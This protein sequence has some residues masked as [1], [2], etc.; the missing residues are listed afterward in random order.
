MWLFKNILGTLLE[1]Q[2]SSSFYYKINLLWSLFILRLSPEIQ[3]T[4]IDFGVHFQIVKYSTLHTHTQEYYNLQNLVELPTWSLDTLLC[5]S[6]TWI[7][8][9]DSTVMA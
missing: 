4:M 3:G 9:L 6:Y 5:V 2:F 1:A 7:K 8:K